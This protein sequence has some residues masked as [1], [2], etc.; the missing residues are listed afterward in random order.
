MRHLVA[1]VAGQHALGH[2]D[3]LL[4]PVRHTLKINSN[5]YFP[6]Y[7]F[8][9]ETHL[10]ILGSTL[11]LT[12]CLSSALDCALFGCRVADKVAPGGTG[13]GGVVRHSCVG[14]GVGVGVHGGVVRHV[15]DVSRINPIV[16]DGGRLV[17]TTVRLLVVNF[18]RSIRRRLS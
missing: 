8:S 15:G 12:Q 4:Q 11:P 5:Y 18:D 13:A 6:V 3:L 17:V 9:C 16:R 2:H 10:G 1:V 7:I 14:Q